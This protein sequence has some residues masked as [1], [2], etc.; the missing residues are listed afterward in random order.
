MDNQSPRVGDADRSAALERLG[1]YFADGYLDLQEFDDRTGRAATA[2]TRAD[3][4]AVFAD[5]PQQR[6]ETNTDIAAMLALRR[7]RDIT[8]ALVGVA[9]FVTF[10]LLQFVMAPA[11]AFIAF[12]ITSALIGITY[13]S[14]GISDEEEKELARLDKQAKRERAERLRVAGERRK[15]LGG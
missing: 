3:L 14:F 10:L 15:E 5:L 1:T 12:P 8:C 7:K 6:Q 9:G 11:F 2:R 4:E 13:M